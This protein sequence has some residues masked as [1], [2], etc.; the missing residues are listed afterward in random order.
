MIPPR[1]DIFQDIKYLLLMSY[2]GNRELM[3]KAR[4]LRSNMTQAEIILWSRLRS[5]QIDGYKFRRQQPIFDYVV[6]FYCDELKLII[7]VD[8]EIHSLIESANWDIKRDKILKIN[9]NHII[10][11]SNIEIETDIDASIRKIRTYIKT[12]L[13]PSQGD[14][15][16][17]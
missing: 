1:G 5:K 8:G 12:N 13:S 11:L 2:Y 10:R 4:I 7:E 17:S 14:Y 15:R 9:G 3:K 16:G 6:D